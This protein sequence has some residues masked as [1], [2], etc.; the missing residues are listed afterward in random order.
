MNAISKN[1]LLKA[2]KD[3]EKKNHPISLDFNFENGG[4]PITKS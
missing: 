3:N 1:D 2:I 4:F